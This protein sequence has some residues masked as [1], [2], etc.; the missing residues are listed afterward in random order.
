MPCDTSHAN[1]MSQMSF[2]DLTRA[3]ECP[4]LQR[5]AGSDCATP[6]TLESS[7]GDG[8]LDV[9]YDLFGAVPLKKRT[10]KPLLPLNTPEEESRCV[11]VNDPV[12]K[13]FD[14]VSCSTSVD[15]NMG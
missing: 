13:H 11:N 15:T 12:I 9:C 8:D 4:H 7:C 3:S 10:R 2:D 14:P 5:L 6:S 1:L